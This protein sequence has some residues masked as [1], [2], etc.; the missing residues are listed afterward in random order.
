MP[1]PRSLEDLDELGAMIRVARKAPPK[2]SQEAI[3]AELGIAQSY[4][5]AIERGAVNVDA[6]MLERLERVLG[7]DLASLTRAAA[8]RNRARKQHGTPLSE[9]L[10]EAPTVS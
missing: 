10:E 4:L 9:P 8:A 1:V 3:A 5:S 7:L 2:R 6:A